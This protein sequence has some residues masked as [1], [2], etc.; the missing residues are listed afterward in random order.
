VQIDY[1]FDKVAWHGPNLMSSLRGVDA[2]HAMKRVRGRRSIW[3]QALHCAYWKQRVINKLVGTQKFP[4]EGSNWPKLP[5]FPT[6]G[7]WRKDVRLLQT[8][9]ASLRAAVKRLDPKKVDRTH[10]KL[11]LG[12]AAHDSYHAGQIRLLRRMLGLS[13]RSTGIA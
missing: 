11:I 13:R 10:A 12:A 6:A 3:E 2:H 7:A 4:R 1:A 9:H 5:I 8:L